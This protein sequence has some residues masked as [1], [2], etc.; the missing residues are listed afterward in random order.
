MVYDK[1][2]VFARLSPQFRTMT[3][4]YIQSVYNDG[5]YCGLPDYPGIHGQTAIVVGANG[6]SGQYMLRQLAKHPQ[7]WTKVFS[8]SRR[9]PQGFDVPQIQHVSVD[10]LAGVDSIQQ[11]LEVANVSA[12]YVFFFAYKESSGD[13]GKLWGGQDQ[14]VVENSMSLSASTPL[15]SLMGFLQVKCSAISFWL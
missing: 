6:I 10:L 12:D 15:A 9:L 2:A 14:M 4:P 13:D 3:T 7:R 5:P 11:A 8:L 1:Q